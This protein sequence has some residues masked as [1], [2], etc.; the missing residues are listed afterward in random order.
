V[1]QVDD[2]RFLRVAAYGPTENEQGLWQADVNFYATV[3]A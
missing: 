3:T 2:T 1:A